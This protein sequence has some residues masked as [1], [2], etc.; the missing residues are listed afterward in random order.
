MGETIATT[1]TPEQDAGTALIQEPGRFPGKALCASQQK[2]N[3]TMSAR[4]ARPPVINQMRI[5]LAMKRA[6]EAAQPVVQRIAQLLAQKGV[7]AHC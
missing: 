4:T 7:P 2:T 6:Q 1:N 5:L 3:D